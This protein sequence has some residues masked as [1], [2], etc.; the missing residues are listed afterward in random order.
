[1][2]NPAIGGVCHWAARRQKGE[3]GNVGLYPCSRRSSHAFVTRGMSVGTAG[4]HDNGGCF[5]RRIGIFFS[6]TSYQRGGG[7]IN[8]RSDHVS[9]YDG[10]RGASYVALV[11]RKQYE[12]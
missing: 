9:I 1:M 8:R 5:T 11:S 3:A 7:R 2:T 6:S 12:E 10:F 4:N